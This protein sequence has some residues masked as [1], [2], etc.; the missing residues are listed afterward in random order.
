MIFSIS[1]EK[2]TDLIEPTDLIVGPKQYRRK[3]INIGPIGCGQHS[4]FIFL[5]F[6]SEK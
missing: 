1:L 6:V 5:G 4:G 2:I 3:F